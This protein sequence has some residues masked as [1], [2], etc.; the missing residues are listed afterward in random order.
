MNPP[1]KLIEYLDAEDPDDSFVGTFSGLAYV[2]VDCY[3]YAERNLQ[4][5]VA[6][7]FQGKPFDLKYEKKAEEEKSKCPR[8]PKFLQR[9]EGL[10]NLFNRIFRNGS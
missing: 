2:T 1:A 5:A 8:L 10:C 3:D 6:V 7:P 9:L 4:G